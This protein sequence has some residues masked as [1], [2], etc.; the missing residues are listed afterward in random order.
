M[1]E[2]KEPVPVKKIQEISAIKFG[3]DSAKNLLYNP[4]KFSIQEQAEHLWGFFTDYK[5]QE[6]SIKNKA[7]GETRLTAEVVDP[8]KIKSSKETVQHQGPLGKQWETVLTEK[9][10]LLEAQ[11]KCGYFFQGGKLFARTE[12]K[13]PEA[14]IAAYKQA[15]GEAVKAGS[16]FDRQLMAMVAADP[17]AQNTLRKIKILWERPEVQ[18]VFRESY[19][20]AEKQR[21]AGLKEKAN[22]GFVKQKADQARDLFFQLLHKRFINGKDAP[23]T[24]Q[25][26]IDL[27][28]DRL[29]EAEK[30]AGETVRP[31]ELM[32]ENVNLAAI[33]KYDDLE[34]YARDFQTKGFIWSPSR[35]KLLGS[36]T[37][38]LA[39][40]VPTL[41]VGEAGSGKTQLA[42]TAVK[43]LQGE[44]PRAVVGAPFSPA[45]PEL[46]GLQQIDGASG[47]TSWT[48]GELIA[49]ATGFQ[50]SKEMKT[51]LDQ[52]VDGIKKAGAKAIEAT[53]SIIF[54]DEANLFD[55]G[56]FESYIKSI[57][58]LRP[59]ESFR[60]GALPGVALRIAE[61]GFGILLAINQADARYSNRNEFPPS[62][63]RLFRNGWTAV[64]YPEMK[65]G[66]A[67]EG[68][69]ENK[70]E[71]FDMLLA[72]LMTRD[73]RILLSPNQ[74][75][76]V[77]EK[78]EVD[79]AAGTHTM[80]VDMA[81]TN[82]LDY[83]EEEISR[84]RTRKVSKEPSHGALF[85]FAL[86]VR[87]TNDLFSEKKI[88]LPGEQAILSDQ[89]KLTYT[90][91]DLGVVMTWMK[92][93]GGRAG[94]D[95]N[96]ELW[97]RLQQFSQTIP[98]TA[99]EDLRVFKK[100]AA[101]HGFDLSLEP[102][103]RPKPYVQIL[104]ERE[105]GNLSP[106]V[107]RPILQRGEEAGPKNK[108]FFDPEGTQ[109][110]IDVNPLSIESED[111][112]HEIEFRE[113]LQLA[114]KI[115]ATTRDLTFLGID[116]ASRA[117]V[118]SESAA[119]LQKPLRLP[120]DR[121]AQLVKAGNVVLIVS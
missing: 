46:M 70:C 9:K 47:Q 8:K 37:K 92:E 90:V 76:P 118:L 12:V 39:N 16:Q 23:M 96:H 101:A 97:Q 103:I 82:F 100:L 108:A 72:S 53:G 2:I 121:F 78:V 57:I 33:S 63:A 88:I 117:V 111:G 109:H 56:A 25:V 104:S 15:Y 34:K 83:S 94:I 17:E 106:E 38:N 89:D 119:Q 107:P 11:R 80:V 60:A 42:R 113:G 5:R 91:L 81:K 116:A 114:I 32:R 102:E 61:K 7:V 44:F 50:G 19:V 110:L 73:G 49:A 55:P 6:A 28:E 68:K 51:Y 84:G 54:I 66:P 65:I 22:Y 41:L 98:K 52:F 18:K 43:L 30:L 85:R 87:A 62:L 29:Q 120:K 64:D 112:V 31:E 10:K 69:Q 74:I 105:I 99:S 79:K 86:L 45:K 1:S 24:L 36:I 77:Y 115:G 95:L 75:Q 20:A 93:L 67:N 13:P 71:L 59:G 14:D 27:A 26:D 40:M 21:L 3:G 4:E 58:G 35:L 48:F